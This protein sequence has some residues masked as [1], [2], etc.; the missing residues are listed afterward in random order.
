MTKKVLI[1]W[2]ETVSYSKLV[3]LPEGKT[4]EGLKQGDEWF[5]MAIQRDG[6]CYRTRP[7]EVEHRQLLSIEEME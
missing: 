7:D 1:C 4:A 5:E 2:S 6:Y 3:P